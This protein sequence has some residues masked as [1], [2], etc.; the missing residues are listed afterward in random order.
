M[1]KRL[2]SEGG[3]TSRQIIHHLADSHM[4]SF[5]RFKLA[6]NE[7][8]PT[9]KPYNQD[10]WANN[11]DSKSPINSSLAILDG[12]HQRLV[13]VLTH[14]SEADYNR[15]LHHPEMSR[16]LTLDFMAGLYAWHS[17]HHAMQIVQLKERQ[18]W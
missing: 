17:K 7:D 4:N 11:Q 12:V 18:G 2:K 8:N 6:L 16:E 9:I 1:H 14:M 5:I 3:W 10:A 15:T 13:D